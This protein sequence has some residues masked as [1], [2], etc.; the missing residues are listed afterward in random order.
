MSRRLRFAEPAAPVKRALPVF[1]L[2]RS[3]VEAFAASIVS[4]RS[5]LEAGGDALGA[6]IDRVVAVALLSAPL[7]A[8]AAMG[9]WLASAALAFAAGLALLAA[10]AFPRRARAIEAALSVALALIGLALAGAAAC[11]IL[12]ERRYARR[13][14][15]EPGFG[16]ADRRRPFGA[17][18]R[19]GAAGPR[20]SRR[21]SNCLPSALPR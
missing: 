12:A 1:G 16:A 9:Y 17:E 8:G 2:P 10:R 13:G 15:E 19:G 18:I 11:A 3:A 14:V 20:G 4:A 5:R 7:A 6:F 21:F